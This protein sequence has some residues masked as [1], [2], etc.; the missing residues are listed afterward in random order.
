[1]SSLAEESRTLDRIGVSDRAGGFMIFAVVAFTFV[2]VAVFLTAALRNA[3]SAA[4]DS[5]ASA[6]YGP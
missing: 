3:P 2:L 5:D 4:A 1:M 6:L